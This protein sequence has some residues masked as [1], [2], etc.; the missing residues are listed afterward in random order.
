MLVHL[1]VYVVEVVDLGAE[2]FRGFPEVGLAH[3]K[4]PILLGLLVAVEVEPSFFVGFDD[5]GEESDVHFFLRG[6]G[7]WL[8]SGRFRWSTYW[9]GLRISLRLGLG[10][11][12][13]RSSDW[14]ELLSRL[15]LDDLDGLSIWL[16]NLG[17]DLRRLNDL[18]TVG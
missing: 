8:L 7:S 16:R 6:S 17:V 4:H 12:L 14:S 11:G 5:P 10:L 1:G 3:Q 15:G 9:G 2:G 18:T 13:S